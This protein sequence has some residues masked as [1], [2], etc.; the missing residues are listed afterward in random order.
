MVMY[1]PTRILP[2]CL[3]VLVLPSLVHR[4]RETNPL[5]SSRLSVRLDRRHR[6]PVYSAP[7]PV[8][9]FYQLQHLLRHLCPHFLQ[10]ASPPHQSPLCLLF[11]LLHQMLMDRNETFL[12]S[13]KNHRLDEILERNSNSTKSAVLAEIS[14]RIVKC[15]S[16]YSSFGRCVVSMTRER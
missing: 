11:L 12:S 3:V 7:V 6:C 13:L 15:P 1:S 5:P 8:S 4:F 14:V 10:I 9:P 2:L 16:F